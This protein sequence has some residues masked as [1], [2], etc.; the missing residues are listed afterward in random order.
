[1]CGIENIVSRRHIAI[2]IDV[3]DVETIS[4]VGIGVTNTM[5]TLML[6]Q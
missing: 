1:M 6:N 4:A 3:L 2:G 5:L